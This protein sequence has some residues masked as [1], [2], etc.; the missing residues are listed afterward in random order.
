MAFVKAV[1]NRIL[2]AK[3][4]SVPMSVS[5]VLV[6]TIIIWIRANVGLVRVLWKAA[7]TALMP[8]IVSIAQSD[9]FTMMQHAKNAL[10]FS[11]TASCAQER[12]NVINVWITSILIRISSAN[13]V[14]ISLKIAVLA[15][16]M[17][18]TALLVVLAFS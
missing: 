7:S 14:E 16:W 12:R 10:L 5:S 6:T 4:A 17:G 18:L 8:L 15:A 2:F 11:I 13:Y 3:T 1:I 9:T